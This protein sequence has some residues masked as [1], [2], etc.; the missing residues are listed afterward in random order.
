MREFGDHQNG[1]QERRTWLTT[2]WLD[3]PEW[4]RIEPEVG[5]FT[6]RGNGGGGVAD[7]LFA[8][9]TALPHISNFRIHD[10]TQHI[11]DHAA[12]TF[13]FDQAALVKTTPF[14]RLNIRKLCREKEKF[15]EALSEHAEE[16]QKELHDIENRV[17]ELAE[18]GR[19][20]SFSDRTAV[21]DVANSM[22]CDTV[23]SVANH[24]AGTTHFRGGLAGPQLE[25]EHIRHIARLREEAI[26]RANEDRVA[27]ND[28]TI[29]HLEARQFTSALRKAQRRFRTRIFQ[30]AADLAVQNPAGEAKRLACI[31][32]RSRRT[33]SKLAPD[34]MP[35]HANHFRSTFGAQPTG[36]HE[37]DRDALSSTDPTLDRIPLCDAAT[38]WLT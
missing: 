33:T 25:E 19:P 4:H 20:L 1:P 24:V 5:V 37:P 14:S 27:G 34:E 15:A 29:A 6:S 21:V 31:Q 11:S 2:H 13:C 26:R 9:S 18:E 12:L 10:Q 3:H 28:S 16:L 38:A 23:L 22:I 36:T 30:A 35:D 17:Y 32:A 7:L 8:N